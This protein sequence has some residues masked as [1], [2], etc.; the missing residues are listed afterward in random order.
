MCPKEFCPSQ[1]LGFCVIFWWRLL[2]VSKIRKRKRVKRMDEISHTLPTTA[3]PY[4]YRIMQMTHQH[5]TTKVVSCTDEHSKQIYEGKSVFSIENYVKY[6]VSNIYG[7]AFLYVCIPLSKSKIT[8][9]FIWK[10]SFSKFF[11]R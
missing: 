3:R 1:S 5:V 2:N 6:L 7:A 8:N 10:L 4:M 11:D 9:V